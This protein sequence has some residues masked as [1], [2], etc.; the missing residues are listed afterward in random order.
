MEHNKAIIKGT[1]EKIGETQTFESGFQKRELV[2]NTGT[3]YPQSIPMQ[4]FKANC[5]I[6]DN[7]G[8]GQAV[9]VNV[10]IRGRKYLER[11]YIDLIAWKIS[12]TEEKEVQHPEPEVIATPPVPTKPGELDF[13]DQKDDLPF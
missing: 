9:E 7:Y 6:L 1:I 5:E 3:E 4:F 11:Y 2:V 13:E 10:D 8:E 12:A